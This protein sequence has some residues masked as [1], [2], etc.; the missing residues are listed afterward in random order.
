MFQIY[1]KDTIDK[2]YLRAKELYRKFG[3][4]ADQV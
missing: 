1:S 3:V 2:D 4:D